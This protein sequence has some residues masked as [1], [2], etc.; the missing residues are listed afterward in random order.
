MPEGCLT[1]DGTKGFI[2][3]TL[4]GVLETGFTKVTDPEARAHLLQRLHAA[5]IK[6]VNSEPG[7]AWHNPMSKDK[8]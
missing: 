7:G 3:G 6:L 1:I 5:H 8:V 4:T 2:R